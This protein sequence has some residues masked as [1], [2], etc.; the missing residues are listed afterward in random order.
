MSG[1]KYYIETLSMY[2]P[3]N[4]KDLWWVDM[5]DTPMF[6]M[7][8]FKPLY[9]NNNGLGTTGGFFIKFKHMTI[10]ELDQLHG[11]L[12]V[13]IDEPET[14]CFNKFFSLY[15]YKPIYE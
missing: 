2:K 13:C 15:V 7:R 14:D 5:E 6:K 8:G 3:L 12:F 9:I 11:L 10:K 1:R 4:I